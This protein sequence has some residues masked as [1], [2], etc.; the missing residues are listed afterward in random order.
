[1][2]LFSPILWTIHGDLY[3]VWS[4]TETALQSASCPLQ[5]EKSKVLSLSGVIT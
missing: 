1:M 4:Y 2:N 3:T 5:S